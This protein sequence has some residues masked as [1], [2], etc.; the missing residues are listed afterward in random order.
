[1]KAGFN[2]TSEITYDEY[3]SSQSISDYLK[4]NFRKLYL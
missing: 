4:H 1:M 3:S 2:E